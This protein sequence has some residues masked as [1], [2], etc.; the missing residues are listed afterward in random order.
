MKW[1]S[2]LTLVRHA[3]SE[4][5]ALKSKKQE[6]PEWKDFTKMFNKGYNAKNFNNAVFEGEWPTPE[7]VALAKSVHRQIREV[8]GLHSDFG[9]PLSERG[10]WQAR[11]TGKKLHAISH[12]SPDIVYI[13]P[14][15]RTRQTY[16]GIMSEWPALKDVRVVEEE[17]IREQEHGMSTVYND[18]RIFS[19]M[20]PEQ[21]AL[22]KQ[23]GSYYWRHPQGESVCDVRERNRDFLSML[24]REQAEQKVLAVTHHLTILSTRANLERWGQAEFIETDEKAKPYNCGV[25]IYKGNPDAGRNGRLELKEY[26]T[27]HYS[28]DR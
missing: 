25:T 26:N 9:T 13:S 8:F 14:Y 19:V 23:T 17:R 21:A 27:K 3:E 5:N 11:E 1:P 7:L 20:N 24:I 15:L 22:Q 6:I 16:E 2:S 12:E 4:Y 18:W 10:H 28:D